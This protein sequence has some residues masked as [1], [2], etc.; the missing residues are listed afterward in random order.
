[1]P[2]IAPGSVEECFFGAV[3]AFNWSE[4]YQGPVILMSEMSMAERVQNIPRPDLI[5]GGRGKPADLRR[6]QRISPLL[7]QRVVSNAIA[8][9]GHPG[10]YVANGSEHDEMGDTT[11]LPSRHI[12][13]TERRF[14]KLKLLEEDHYESDNT[15]AK[16]AL[17]PWGGS[18]GPVLEAYNALREEGVD[19]AWYYTM[20]LHPIPPKLRDELR[21]KELV[22]VPELNYQ[23]QWANILRFHRVASTPITQYT[24]L[25]FKVS[26]LVTQVK[27]IM[28][29]HM[30]EARA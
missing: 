10:A 18:K 8:T 5:Q 23:G 22:I 30:E 20:F 29:E 2:V 3:H 12:Q 7:R 14:G 27:K 26:D 9:G 24:G 1:M 25:P 15:A 17:M 4:R 19:I 21:A 6:H 13:M 16:F 11:H 28:A